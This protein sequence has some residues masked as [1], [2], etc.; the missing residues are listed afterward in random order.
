MEVSGQHH[1]PTALTADKDPVA[2]WI[3]GWLDPRAHCLRSIRKCPLRLSHLIFISSRCGLMQMQ[4]LRSIILRR[5]EWILRIYWWNDNWH[6]KKR[7]SWRQS[8]PSTI[9]PTIRRTWT[10]IE[11]N[12]FPW[13]GSEYKPHGC[14]RGSLVLECLA[15]TCLIKKD[16]GQ[17]NY[18]VRYK[19]ALLYN[20]V[21]HAQNN[22]I[23]RNH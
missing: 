3:G 10:A 19:I 17:L 12:L 9:S 5:S 16:F 13:G 8:Y 22:L 6:E 23:L 15:D 7:S 2:H 21:Y 4:A 18:T 1:A 14:I 20:K 11:L